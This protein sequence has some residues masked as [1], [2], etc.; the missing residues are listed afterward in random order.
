MCWAASARAKAPATPG[1]P[2]RHRTRGA[3]WR[4]QRQ[5]AVVVGGAAVTGG[6]D[7][8]PH[9]GGPRL[10]HARAKRDGGVAGVQLDGPLRRVDGHRAPAIHAQ[11]RV[12]RAVRDDAH[13]QAERLARANQIGRRQLGD[14]RVRLAQG[15]AGGR[16]RAATPRW[17]RR[18]AAP[19]RSPRVA[20][21]SDSSS[22]RG[23]A[24]AST[25]PAA[26]LNASAGSVACPP[27]P[28]RCS[29]A[30]R[31][32]LVWLGGEAQHARGWIPARRRRARDVVDHPL[33]AGE[34]LVGDAVGDV[35]QR[36]PATRRG[37]C[38]AARDRPAPA[39][40]PRTPGRARRPAAD[41]LPAR[42]VGQRSPADRRQH[43]NRSTAPATPPDVPA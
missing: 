37:T 28:I 42:K 13:V 33:L 32:H 22:T 7:V 3:A 29:R 17:P 2:S 18:R 24:V 19:A 39:R 6:A 41:Q 40:R 1:A 27:T 4:R 16:R 35:G 43:R 8:G 34:R 15:R 25:S 20:S 23:T 21:P 12:A 36:R 10:Q 9:D 26:R 38:R 14:R 5:H 31:R 30:A 11:L